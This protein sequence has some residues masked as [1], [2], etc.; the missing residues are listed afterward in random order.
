MNS[1]IRDAHNFAWKAGLVV[2]DKFPEALLETYELER[3]PHARALIEMA[4]IMGRFI[5]PA[6]KLGAWIIQWGMMI[7]RIIPVA[8]DYIAQMKFKPR[9]FFRHGLLNGNQSLIGRLFIQP[10]VE[11]PDRSIELLDDVIG[12]S[13]TCLLFGLP[14]E[15]QTICLEQTVGNETPISWLWVTP[16]NYMPRNDGNIPQVRDINGAVEKAIKGF[17]D[18]AVLLRPDHY[19][20]ALIPRNLLKDPNCFQNIFGPKFFKKI[21]VSL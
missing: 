13:F 17:T 1:G 20:S 14:D 18:Y 12:N 21:I 3:K 8:H 9:P 15:D 16:R 5:M 10:H 4:V 19:V 2:K 6:S 7:S 11:R